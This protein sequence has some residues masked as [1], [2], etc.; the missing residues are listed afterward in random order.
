MIKWLRIWKVSGVNWHTTKLANASGDFLCAEK[1][2]GF[3]KHILIKTH[4]G[5]LFAFNFMC[6]MA[7]S[8]KL[9]PKT[10]RVTT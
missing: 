5:F 2:A 4:F 10:K 6:K 9:W 8:F 3:S 1:C 7:Q